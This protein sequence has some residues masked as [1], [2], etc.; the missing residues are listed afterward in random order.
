MLMF[1]RYQ[2][3]DAANVKI[4]A[5]GY[6][7]ATPR[8]ARTG[9][10]LYYGRE[11]GVAGVDANKIFK[12]YRPEDQV[13]AKD[14]MASFAYKPVCD[15]HP[16]EN[17]TVN[18]WAKYSKG[19]LSGDVARDGDFI[20]V[21]MALMDASLVKK[22]KDGKAEISMGYECE[23]VWQAGTTPTGD[24]YDASQKTIR[25]NHG[26]IVDAARGGQ[27][28]RF[29]DGSGARIDLSV[30]TSALEAITSGN[31]NRDS[32]LAD[33]NGHLAKDSKG[34]SIYPI[35]KD[36]VVYVS[37]LRASKTDAVTKG[38][39]DVVAAI[40]NLLT[41]A[42]G[43]TNAV[44]DG[45]ENETMKIMQ[46]DGISVEVVN[47][48]AAQIIQ[49]ALD[50]AAARVKTAEDALAKALA[51]AAA[52]QTT[53][54]ADTAKHTTESTTKDA[55]IVTLKK[56]VED[57]KLTPAK[58]DQ[59]VKDRAFTAGKARAILGDKLVVDGKTDG[60]IMKQ[61]VDAKLGDAAKGWN[62]D[63][64][65]ISFDTLTA[66]TK[67]ID[68]AS[69]GVFDT[70]RAFSGGDNGSTRQLA[71]KAADD[72]D[73]RLANAWKTPVSGAQQ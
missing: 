28:L 14:S 29:G 17:V 66:G 53:L 50:T 31:V 71:D 48:Q 45:K 21:P 12:V 27:E 35:L 65:K 47:D 67:P 42:E 23:I 8:V 63:Q 20:R 55:E 2:F 24:A 51:D 57:G 41:R 19:Q 22:Y 5:D 18:N 37:S 9:I 36:G 70:A 11:L 4:T 15:D 39:G 58:L 62:D 46:V 16:P 40:D 38:D 68:V 13:F 49:K 25:I 56:Q 44:S 60:E 69:S 61:V 30:Y 54:A 3:D 33:A 72:R 52:L 10:Q 1:D 34:I 59:L 6:L 7:V 26:A 43:T 73:A 64:V 32:A